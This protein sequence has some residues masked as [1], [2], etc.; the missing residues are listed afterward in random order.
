MLRALGLGD[1]LTALPALR[2]LRRSFAG[3]ELVLAAPAALRPLADQAQ[4]ADRFWPVPAA[5]RAPPTGLAWPEPPPALAVNLH[6]CGPQSTAAL[7]ELRPGRLWSYGIAGGPAWDPAEHE[8]RRWSRLVEHYGG[9]T[10]AEDLYLS[11][12]SE[13]AGSA[14]IHPGAASAARRW[15]ARRYARVAAGVAGHGVD[16]RISAGPGEYDLAAAVAR[17]AGLP[18]AA[19]LAG[20]DLRGLTEAVSA[21]PLVVCADTG[22]AHLATACRT[23]SVVLFGPQPPSRWGPPPGPRHRVL[24]HPRPG[25]PDPPDRPHP[26]L[27]RISATEVLEA[28]IDLLDGTPA[29]APASRDPLSPPRWQSRR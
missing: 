9:R 13:R 12:P 25:E 4:L 20:L 28:A 16:V 2:G 10:Y 18:P 1:L 14:I 11:A 6:G 27:L 5:V 17:A 22:L 26:A 8:V 7:R 15:P 23:R 19:V 21:S 3:A 24:W 29:P